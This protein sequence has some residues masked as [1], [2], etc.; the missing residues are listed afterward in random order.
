MYNFMK[1]IFTMKLLL[2]IA[3]LF[4]VSCNSNNEKKI[5]TPN[6]NQIAVAQ[7][8]YPANKSPLESRTQTLTLE[9]IVWGCACA[10]WITKEDYKK[11]QDTGSLSAH[12][13]F[14]EPADSILQISDS[15]DFRLYNL[16]F[17]Y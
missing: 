15:T 14:I 1:H 6:Q 5:V 10:N 17:L 12:C 4:S 11:Y 3:I 9:Y 2:Q 13:I 16:R 8:Y 7:V